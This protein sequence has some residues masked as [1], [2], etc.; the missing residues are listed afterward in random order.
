VLIVEDDLANRTIFTRIALKEGWSVT[1]ADNGRSA[2]EAVAKSIPD[3]ILLD[4]GL[5]QLDGN[6]FLRELRAK[7][8]W[9][10][11]PVVVITAR[12]LNREDRKALD[13]LVQGV[14]VFQ[15][16]SYSRAELIQELRG[17][18]RHLT[19]NPPPTDRV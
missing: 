13:E 9:R 4:L 12:D 14:A 6:G 2:L 3:L 5:P 10:H 18:V 15:K 17:R 8:E 7:P 11:I 16:G 1:E 19:T